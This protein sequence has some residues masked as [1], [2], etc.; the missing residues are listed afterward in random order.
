MLKAENISFSCYCWRNKNHP[1]AA[2]SDL[3]ITRQ[4]L[5]ENE[6][7]RE[8]SEGK[9]CGNTDWD[10]MISVEPHGPGISE[11]RIYCGFFNQW[12]NV[13]SFLFKLDFLSFA[14]M[15]LYIFF[16][17]IA[18]MN[19]SQYFDPFVTNWENYFMHYEKFYWIKLLLSMKW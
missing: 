15:S 1:A 13:F 4:S 3:D 12:A 6:A 10:I 7:N 19:Y 5:P 16:S 14:T 17:Q 18:L 11:S 9:G 8:K 2:G